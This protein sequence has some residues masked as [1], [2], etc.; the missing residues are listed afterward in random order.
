MGTGRHSLLAEAHSFASLMEVLDELV[1]LFHDLNVILEQL[2]GAWNTLELLFQLNL[3]RVTQVTL[4]VVSCDH[5][6]SILLIVFV[7]HL[8]DLHLVC[9][10]TH[11]DCLKLFYGHREFNRFP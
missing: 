11:Q 8:V 1:E 4:N 9:F 10:L 7:E 5:L 3:Y 6:A 2:L